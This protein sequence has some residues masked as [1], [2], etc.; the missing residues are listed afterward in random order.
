MTTDVSPTLRIAVLGAPGGYYAEQLERASLQMQCDVPVQVD[1]I[2][3]RQLET[4][5]LSGHVHCLDGFDACI[6]RSMPP[7]SLEHVIFRMDCLHSFEAS[8]RPVFNPARCLEAAI[9]KWLTLDRLARAGLRVPNTIAC[10]SRAVAMNAFETLGRDVVVKPIFGGE[11]RGI[12]RVESEALAL[13]VF[14]SLDTLAS[15]LYVQEFLPHFG[16][17]IRILFVGDKSFAIKR[18]A[19]DGW[20][21]NIA[22]GGRAEAYEPTAEEMSIARDAARAI[23]GSIVGVDLLP[24]KQAG[25]V[26]LEVNAVPGWK[27]NEA[28]HQTDIGL[29]VLEHVVREVLRRR[30]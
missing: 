28:V 5:L 2:D 29:A 1:T 19:V 30:A 11:G 14:N 25:I 23:G 15:V 21:T 9:D 20:L 16:Y 18:H 6:A 12:M 10:Q 7:G 8:G 3:Y 13:R 4:R 22:Q 24:T 17:D 27:A 26:V